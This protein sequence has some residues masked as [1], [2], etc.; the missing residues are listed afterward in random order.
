MT[1]PDVN[2]GTTRVVTQTLP[3]VNLMPAEIAEA[4]RFRRF[5]L[6][7]GAAVVAAV[8]IVAA[9]YVHGKSDVH[10][11]EA[12]IAQAQQ[13]HAT[14]QHEL[15]GLSNVSDIYSQ[16]AAKEAMVQQAMGSQVDWSRYLSDLSLRVPDNVWLSGLQLTQSN[17]GLA[18]TATAPVQPGAQLTP[19]GIAN[20]TFSGVAFSHDDV[21]TWLDMLAKEKGFANAYFSNSTK[22]TIGKKSVVNFTSTVTVTD[23]AKSNRFTKPAGN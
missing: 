8:A 2:Q 6:A 19:T 18:A 12:D 5:Q 21:A 4:A 7:M 22:A 10:S 13:D 14:V 9:L 17:T 3:S 16:V 20:I 11:A 23:D 1:T 15:D